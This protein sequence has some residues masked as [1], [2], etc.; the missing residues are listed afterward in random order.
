M[1]KAI[2]VS[3]LTKVF[4]TRKK[5]KE[6]KK[7]KVKFTAVDNINFKVE[8]G[9]IVGFI[10]PNGAGKSTTIKMMTGIL[11]PTSGDACVAGF[12]P[13]RERKIM[14]YKIATMFGQKSSLIAHLPVIESYR[15]LGAIY[16]IEKNVLEER[17]QEIVE[18]F[19]ISHLI[20]QKVSSLSLG[21]RMIC[22]V[23]AVTLHRPEII[24]FDEPTI[25]LDLVAKKKVR[26]MIEMLNK[27]YNTTI[28]ITSHDISDIEKLCSRI[29]IINHG[30]VM[31]DNSILEIKK[32]YLTLKK[33]DVTFDC[34]VDVKT[35][36]DKLKTFNYA[37]EGQDKVSIEFDESLIK[38]GKIIA[39]LLEVGDIADMTISTTSL[40][41]II[42]DIYTDKSKEEET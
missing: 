42:Y 17:I 24:F 23:A 28:F 1:K 4:E 37:F 34:D 6:G 31:L 18:F 26:D 22:E 25:G 40:E 19:G 32:K 2:V 9:E 41:N 29:I 16:D 3:N 33:L 39:K 21:Q 30:K 38:P 5:N 8:Q 14:T 27:K 15:L 20:E 7:E 13:W 12:N 11:Y 35:A 36:E 10:G